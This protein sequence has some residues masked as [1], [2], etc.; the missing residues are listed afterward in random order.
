MERTLDTPAGTEERVGPRWLR[1]TLIPLFLIVVCPPTAILVWY[2]H[3][4]LGGSLGALGRL[5]AHEG[6]GAV[7]RI[8]S[9]VFF[10]S[11]TAWTVIGVFA[12]TQ[13]LLMR[14]VPGKPFH[15]PI[16]PKGNV[17]VYKANGPAAFAVTL[18]LFFGASYG[19][20]LFPA[21]IVYDHFG[22]II[23]AL[24]V[25]S[26]V[27]CLFLYLKGRYRPSST[28]SGITGNFIFDYY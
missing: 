18:A 1:M 11:A 19:L 3:T 13:L 26:L 22:E 8:F 15:G 12:A 27:F 28:D 21:S 25:F 14:V 7:G 16:T 10:G 24:N 9:P 6:L 5:F 2:T 20:G 23:G 4:A 17:P